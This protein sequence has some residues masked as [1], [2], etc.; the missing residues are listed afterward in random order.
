[1][2]ESL[3]QR[4]QEV[5]SALNEVLS[6]VKNYTALDSMFKESVHD[7]NT[8]IK[9]VLEQIDSKTFTVAVIATIKA[10]KS[11]FLNSLIGNEYLPTSNVPE[12]SSLLYI[13]HDKETFLQKD[14]E[15]IFGL[16]N[17]REAIRNRN[18]KYRDSGV[19][20][21][22]K[23]SLN[24]PYEKISEIESLN[25]QFIDTPGPN[26]AGAISLRTEVEKVLRMAD[27][28]V[29]LLDYTKLNSNDEHL[30]F[31]TISQLRDD[32]V[33]EIKDRLFFVVNKYDSKNENSLSIEQT[34]EFVSNSL[35]NSIGLKTSK[36]HCVSAEKA[37]L[38]RMIKNGNYDR[39]N[40]LGKKS[41][42]DEGWDESNSV[43]EKVK[44]FDGRLLDA[45]ITKTGMPELENDIID[46]IVNNSES[47]F[48]KSIIDKTLKIIQ[49]T[50]NRFLAKLA[51]MQKDESE[52]NRIFHELNNKV[53]KIRCDL[54]KIDGIVNSFSKNIEKEVEKQFDDFE[55]TISRLIGKVVNYKKSNPGIDNKSIE[56]FIDTGADVAI[57]ALAPGKGKTEKSQNRKVLKQ[58]YKLGKTGLKSIVSIVGEWNKKVD[59]DDARKKIEKINQSIYELVQIGFTTVKEELEM[60]TSTHSNEVND[61]L[62]SII[63]RANDELFVAIN[64][65][66][67]MNDQFTVVH[68]ELPKDDSFKLSADYD[69]FIDK[70]MKDKAG[71]FC[72]PQERV[73]DTVELKAEHLAKWWARELKRE[74]TAS[75][76][77]V[78]DYIQEAV[79]KKI[80][81]VKKDF[82]SNAE[83]YLQMIK[84][85]QKDVQK[86]QSKKADYERVLDDSILKLKAIAKGIAKTNFV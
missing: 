74:K 63:N 80:E 27:V 73:I 45:I 41:F 86:A 29:Y 30:L 2:K 67:K 82:N 8:K 13:R 5:S 48:Y 79:F 55:K 76:K 32:L 75:L 66:F 59:P 14:S 17:I 35:Q 77:V 16:S 53:E 36:I 21:L 65:G 15:K 78:K 71:G 44:M 22:V 39:I 69:E 38:A 28:I 34:S 50:E 62:Q 23:Y 3:I 81:V 10:G 84:S 37:L 46:Y 61:E 19:D 4:N 24:V 26:E 43:E 68:I 52:L 11:T 70:T 57:E 1:M 42:G 85:E 64:R 9:E 54:N 51:L 72:R 20:L 49:E 12:T 7:M 56:D 31:G 83:T 18:K 33:S 40:D 47:L 6:I 60:K 25:F 58:I